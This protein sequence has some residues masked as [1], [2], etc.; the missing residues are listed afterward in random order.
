MKYD[1]TSANNPYAIPAHDFASRRF[2]L[3]MQKPVST[4]TAVAHK[5]TERERIAS[6]TEAF[7]RAGGRI[8][9]LPANA[10]AAHGKTQD[11]EE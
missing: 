9:R 3:D 4:G 6:D 8:E 1:G 11:E 10:R 2:W 7:L 5:Q